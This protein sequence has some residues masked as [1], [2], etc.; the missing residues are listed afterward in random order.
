MCLSDEISSSCLF[1]LYTLIL[2]A[3]LRAHAYPGKASHI[4]MNFFSTDTGFILKLM[5][6][7]QHLAKYLDTLLKVICEFQINEESIAGWK[8]ELKSEYSREMA[9]PKSL[10][11]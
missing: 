8:Q 4:S 9:H 5:G 2:N 6:F 3:L 11:K 7:N 1:D 10:I